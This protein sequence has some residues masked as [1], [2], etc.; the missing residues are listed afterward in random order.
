MVINDIYAYYN[1]NNNCHK[2]AYVIRRYTS[3]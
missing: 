1:N 2:L 3:I